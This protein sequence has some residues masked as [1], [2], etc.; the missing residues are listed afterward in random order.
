MMTIL[1]EQGWVDCSGII[2]KQF[3]RMATT[4]FPGMHP[5]RQIFSL[6]QSLEPEF[7]ENFLP[8]AWKGWVDI[9]EEALDASSLTVLQARLRYVAQVK[10]PAIPIMRMHNCAPLSRDAGKF[11]EDLIV[12][13]GEASFVRGIFLQHSG[14]YVEA[15]AMVEEAICCASEGRF[16]YANHMW[17]EC[18]DT[19]AFLQYLNHEDE[20]AQSTLRQV[21]DV[22]STSE[23]WHAGSTLRCLTTLGTWL[24]QFGKTLKKLLRCS[25]R[26]TEILRQSN[27]FV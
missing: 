15:M 24:G 26:F 3:S 4:I 10:W 7:A 18:M 25:S 14:R 9:F 20:E 12:G 19:L 11:M 13:P 16:R 2:Y 23:G 17:C 6:L 21:I 1:R 27:V 5:L 22:R 8:N